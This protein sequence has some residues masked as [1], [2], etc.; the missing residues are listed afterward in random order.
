MDN[1]S[2]RPRGDDRRGFLKRCCAG[3]IGGALVL[4]P[5]TTGMGLLL[6]PLRRGAGG[7][8]LVRVATLDALPADGV[9]RRFPVVARRVDAW[10]TFPD[11]QI[12]AVFLRRTSDGAIEAFNVACPHAGCFVDFLPAARTFHCPCHNSYFTIEGNVAT[13]SSPAPRPLDSLAVEVR[14]GNEIWVRFQNFLSGR[15]AKTPA[16]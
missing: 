5:L 1:E 15:V 10:T 2:Q 11:S 13:P 14:N 12:G 8:Q 9:P 3:A 16:A 6:E 4:V 7:G